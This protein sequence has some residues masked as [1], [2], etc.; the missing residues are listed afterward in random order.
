[1]KQGYGRPLP[2]KEEEKI[3]YRGQSAMNYGQQKKKK[4]KKKK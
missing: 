3:M 4:K 2:E 1:M